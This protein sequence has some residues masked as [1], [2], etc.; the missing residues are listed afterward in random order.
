MIRRPLALIE[1]A[2]YAPPSAKT[3]NMVKNARKNYTYKQFKFNVHIYEIDDINASKKVRSGGPMRGWYVEPA[4]PTSRELELCNIHRDVW[5]GAFQRNK[6][7]AYCHLEIL[8]G[9]GVINSILGH[10]DAR[11]AVNGLI[12][13]MATS[14]GLDWLNYLTL[15]SS[16]PSLRSFKERVG[17]RE[18]TVLSG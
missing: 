7:V 14:L 11:G 12:D 18:Y 3:R 16:P 13:Y 10:K 4:R 6:L 1:C 15:A 2:T 8:E 9:L 5:V 17:F